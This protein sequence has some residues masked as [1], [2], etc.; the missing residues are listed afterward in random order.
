[1]EPEKEG[2]HRIK[3]GQL[4]QPPRF[5]E[6]FVKLLELPFRI[7]R[8]NLADRLCSFYHCMGALEGRAAGPATWGVPESREGGWV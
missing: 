8:A 5:A 4:A 1:M 7:V 3:R 6:R 2:E